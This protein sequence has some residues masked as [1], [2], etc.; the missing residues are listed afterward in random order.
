MRQLPV[1][2]ADLCPRCLEWFPRV[3]FADHTAGCTKLR[4]PDAA[5]Q[6]KAGAR[7]ALRA[8]YLTHVEELLRH[9]AYFNSSEVQELE[10]LHERLHG[11]SSGSHLDE[12]YDRLRHFEAHLRGLQRPGFVNGGSP[13]SGHR[14]H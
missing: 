3:V 7:K 8:S 2:H 14:R 5:S 6:R 10:R 12:E 11:S 1:G 4:E 13:G 9:T